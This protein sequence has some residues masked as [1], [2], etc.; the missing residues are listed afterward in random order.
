MKFFVDLLTYEQNRYQRF[1][2][3]GIKYYLNRITEKIYTI[4]FVSL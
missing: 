3:G 4:E 1:L 2:L